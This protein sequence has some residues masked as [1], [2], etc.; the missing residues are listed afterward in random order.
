MLKDCELQK[1]IE[2]LAGGDMTEIGEKGLN[3]SGG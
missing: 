2:M 1:D 3:L